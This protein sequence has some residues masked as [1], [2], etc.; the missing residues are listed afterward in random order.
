MQL[1]D[2]APC[3]NGTHIVACGGSSSV[4]PAT[5]IVAG[6]MFGVAVDVVLVLAEKAYQAVKYFLTQKENK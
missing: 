5:Y 6:I 3:S 4:E 2:Y 1:I